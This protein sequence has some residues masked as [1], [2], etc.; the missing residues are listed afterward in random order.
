MP[1]YSMM[2]APFLKQI[3]KGEKKLLKAKDVVNCNPPKYDE[4][5]VF[6]LYD[7]CLKMPKMAQYFPDKYAKGRI[8]DR[9]YFFAIL[10]TI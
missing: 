2:T 6:N 3:L 5:S 10:A 7:K 1:P 8:C 4:I 9:K